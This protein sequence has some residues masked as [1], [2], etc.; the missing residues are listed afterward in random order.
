MSLFIISIL[1]SVLNLVLSVFLLICLSLLDLLYIHSSLRY[2][3]VTGLSQGYSE[4]FT[5][6]II[7][8]IS[9]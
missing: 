7:I 9:V 6:F 8:I 2:D 3:A 4:M 5:F 1:S